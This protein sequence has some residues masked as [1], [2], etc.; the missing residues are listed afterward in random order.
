[1]CLDT[2][3]KRKPAKTGFGY[4]VLGRIGKRLMSPI[5]G[6]KSYQLGRWH[7]ADSVWVPSYGHNGYMSGFHICKTKRYAQAW[8]GGPN[9]A[10]YKVEYRGASVIGWQ[11]GELVIVAPEMRIVKKVG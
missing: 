9:S 5:R 6:G 2:I 7:K 1:M 11:E 4:K 10:V 8:A 3:S